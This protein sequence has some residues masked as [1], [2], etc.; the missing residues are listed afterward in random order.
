MVRFRSQISY[1][2]IYAQ[3]SGSGKNTSTSVTGARG[4]M[5]IQPETF[6]QYAKPGE[7]IDNPPT[8][9]LSASASLTT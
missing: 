9:R 1:D 6:A 8:I 3:E 4:G 7:N 5:Q 2:A